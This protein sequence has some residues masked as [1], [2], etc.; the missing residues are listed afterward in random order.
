MLVRSLRKFCYVNWVFGIL[1]FWSVELD[2]PWFFFLEP[3]YHWR[4][5]SSLGGGPTIDNADTEQPPLLF[6]DTTTKHLI[7]RYRQKGI[8]LFKTDTYYRFP[9]L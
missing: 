6:T 3:P 4:F 5:P 9:P 7:A 2:H 1:K 8:G